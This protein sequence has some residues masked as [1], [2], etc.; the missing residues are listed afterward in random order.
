[1]FENLDLKEADILTAVV[2]LSP[3]YVR[4]NIPLSKCASRKVNNLTG[5][6]LSSHECKPLVHRYVQ[7]SILLTET[8]SMGVTAKSL[9]DAVFDPLLA[10]VQEADDEVH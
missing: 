4:F 6:L 9:C 5:L 1:M 10:K 7:S 2:T 8:V 3:R